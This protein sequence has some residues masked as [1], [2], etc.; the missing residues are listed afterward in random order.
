MCTSM[1]SNVLRS[2]ASGLVVSLILAGCAVGPNFVRPAPPALTRYLPAGQLPAAMS[3]EDHPQ[4]FVAGASVSAQWWELFHSPALDQTVS[5]ALKANQSV[6]SAVATLHQSED[7]LRAGYGVFF[8]QI[9]AGLGADRQRASLATFGQAGQSSIFN[10]FTLSGSISYLVDLFGGARR[11]VESLGAD[12]DF[13]HNTVLAAYLSLSANVVNTSIARAG[14]RAQIAATRSLIAA[15]SS[16]V[17]LTKA[18]TQAG[19]APYSA[20]LALQTQLSS[21][22]ASLPPLELRADQADH[23]LAVLAGRAPSE[24]TPPNLALSDF[25]LPENLPLSLPS[26]LVRQRPD[27]LTAEARLHVASAQIGV[28]TAALFPTINLS[29]SLGSSTNEWSALGKQSNRFWSSDAGLTVPVFQGGAA[30]YG[31]KAAMDAFQAAQ[32]DYRQVVLAA[33]QQ[34][35]DVLR[36]L[37]HDAELL[38]A[39]RASADA[40]AENLSMTQANYQAGLVDYL[41]VLSA[42][43]QFQNAQ[44]GLISAQAQQLQDTVAL[45]VAL[46]GGWW[47]TKNPAPTVTVATP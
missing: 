8:P 19:T 46:G 42:T 30:W 26:E 12:V 36:A 37:D 10:L 1:R 28:T 16:E 45:Y 38:R 44:L 33:F 15:A 39:E 24:W 27:I 21:L 2:G 25:S 22:E 17:D 31:R 18:Q 14:Y 20:V 41:T 23:L 40:A 5:D 32:A 9:S 7:Q 34:V 47:N 4:H 13:E 6:A 11:Q 35:A 29:G 43:A 3:A